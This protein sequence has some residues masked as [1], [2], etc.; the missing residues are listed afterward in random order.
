MQ[1]PI[2]LSSKI[3]GN[4]SLAIQAGKT[5]MNLRVKCPITDPNGYNNGC[6]RACFSCFK[7]RAKAEELKNTITLD[8]QQFFPKEFIDLQQFNSNK[9][10]AMGD[11]SEDEA[12]AEDQKKKEKSEDR[13]QSAANFGQND[14]SGPVLLAGE[15]GNSHIDDQ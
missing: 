11:E 8:G 7:S 12:D 4:N 6:L 2:F 14:N 1:Y 10:Q 3:L 13:R 9:V 5:I 15:R